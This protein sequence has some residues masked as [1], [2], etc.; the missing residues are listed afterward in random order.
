[1]VATCPHLLVARGGGPDL[2]LDGRLDGDEDPVW[3][4]HEDEA[5]RWASKKAADLRRLRGADLPP[6]PGEYDTIDT[7]AV[8]QG[9]QAR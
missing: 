1:M 4:P 8:P 9:V 5:T 3:T 2:F 6:L 7:Q